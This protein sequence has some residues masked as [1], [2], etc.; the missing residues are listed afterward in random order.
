MADEK[1]LFERE[2]SGVEPLRRPERVASRRED[3]SALAVAARREAAVNAPEADR[4]FLGL[5]PVELLDPYYPLEFRRPGVQYGVFRK[6]KQG[7]YTMDARL[8]LHRMSAEQARREVFGFIREAQRYDLRTLM[9][10][11]GK[12]THAQAGPALLKSYINRWLPEF[13]EVQAFVSAQPQHGGTVAVYVL[14]KKSA[15][16]KERNREHFS[17]GRVPSA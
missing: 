7:R 14:L 15:A 2:M 11:H 8:D 13:E 1:D 5:D 9:I 4:N 6:L 16:D 10:V 17:R 3:V 12:G